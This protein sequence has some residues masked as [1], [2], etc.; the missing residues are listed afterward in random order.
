MTRTI[1]GTPEEGAPE[2]GFRQAMSWLHTWAGLTLGWV[3]FFIFLTG[4]VGYFDTEID[5]WIQPELPP[6]QTYLD[7]TD[8]APR[9]FERHKTVAPDAER[10]CGFGGV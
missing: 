2:G 5:R 4:T 9:M 7:T 8:T 10:D 1:T 6:A 3:L